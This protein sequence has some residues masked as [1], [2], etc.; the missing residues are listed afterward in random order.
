MFWSVL[1]APLELVLLYHEL[2]N[3]VGIG[4]F[5]VKFVSTVAVRKWDSE[6]RTTLN[7][8]YAERIARRTWQGK[9]W[10]MNDINHKDHKGRTRKKKKR[11]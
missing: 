4:R 7:H 5:P 3:L 1:Y 11:T 2:R 6:L 8:V 10:W 9:N